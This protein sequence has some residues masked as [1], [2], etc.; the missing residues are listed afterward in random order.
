MLTVPELQA[1]PTATVAVAA[2]PSSQR[3]NSHEKALLLKLRNTSSM[4]H[5]RQFSQVGT[6]LVHDGDTHNQ[7]LPKVL[8]QKI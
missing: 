8:R 1:L 6:R 3:G 4:L 2:F 7:R 5:W